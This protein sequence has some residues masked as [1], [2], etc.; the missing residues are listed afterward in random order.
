MCLQTK[1]WFPCAT[2]C[3]NYSLLCRATSHYMLVAYSWKYN[4]RLGWFQSLAGN[5]L[6]RWG[7]P[8]WSRDKLTNYRSLGGTFFIWSSCQTAFSFWSL[9]HGGFTSPAITDSKDTV[10]FWLH[11][12]KLITIPQRI[13]VQGNFEWKR[14]I[15]SLAEWRY[16]PWKKARWGDYEGVI[17]WYHSDVFSIINTMVCPTYPYWICIA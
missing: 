13:L 17:S 1:M 5:L 9:A 8:A 2:A 6:L 16:Q 14:N 7:K 10:L 11:R 12:F 3:G 4:R 15:T